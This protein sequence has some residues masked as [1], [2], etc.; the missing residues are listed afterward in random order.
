M[1][2]Q[3]KSLN[4]GRKSYTVSVHCNLKSGQSHWRKVRYIFQQ[5][6]TVLIMAKSHKIWNVSDQNKLDLKFMRR[7]QL[8]SKRTG[9]FS[10]VTTQSFSVFLLFSD[11]RIDFDLIFVRSLMSFYRGLWRKGTCIAKQKIPT[12]YIRNGRK[13][14]LARGWL[15]NT[16]CHANVIG[17][18]AGNIHSIIQKFSWWLFLCEKCHSMH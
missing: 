7:D 13:R 3:E 15:K 2:L 6:N 9:I 10:P 4:V 5:S 1:H 11:V 14:S 8:C 16:T 17:T 12:T 18:A